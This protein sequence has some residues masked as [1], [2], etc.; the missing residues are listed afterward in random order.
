[1]SRRDDLR[2]NRPVDASEFAVNLE[3]RDEQR[4]RSE[5][6]WQ[7]AQSA[8]S[9]FA[10]IVQFTRAIRNVTFAHPLVKTS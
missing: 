5:L 4:G 1:L 3:D 8:E 9:R 2:E 6:L 10:W 7:D